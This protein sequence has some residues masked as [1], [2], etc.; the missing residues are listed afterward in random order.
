VQRWR[1]QTRTPASTAVLDEAQRLVTPQE[2]TVFQVVRGGGRVTAGTDAPINPYGLS[3]LMELE[4]Y[5]SG[6]L[7]PVEVLRTATMV[8]AEAMG[9]GGDLGS[10]EPG[11]LADLALIDGDPLQN[12][13]D[14]RRVWRMMKDGLVYNVSALV[15][16]R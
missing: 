10:I 6:G 3:L 12:I 1:D 5:A 11:K 9:V 8:S 4:N 2:R 14:L 7:T 13:K 15:A 16:G